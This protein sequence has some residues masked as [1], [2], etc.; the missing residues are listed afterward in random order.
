MQKQTWKSCILSSK[1]ATPQGAEVDSAGRADGAHSLGRGHRRCMPENLKVWFQL[2]IELNRWEAPNV[3]QIWFHPS[4]NQLYTEK[5]L[6]TK[7][8]DRWRRIQIFS[9]RTA[10]LP[11]DGIKQ[12]CTYKWP[13]NGCLHQIITACRFHKMR[14]ITTSLENENIMK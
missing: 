5:F 9:F 3:P 7:S 10:S 11:L 8:K 1:W 12:N 14:L 6:L 2:R 13:L 4:R